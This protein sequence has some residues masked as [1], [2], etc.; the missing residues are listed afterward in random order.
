MKKTTLS[1]LFAALV[2]ISCVFASCN[3]DQSIIKDNETQKPEKDYTSLITKLEN[4][5]IE[6]KQNQYV[7]DAERDKEI[8]RLEGLIA[9]LK[10]STPD[11][12]ETES[13]TE[14]ETDKESETE[15]E[16]T[17]SPE[18]DNK[19]KFLYTITDS[20]AILTGYTGKDQT[21]VIPSSID[22][23][24]IIAIADN[25]FDSPTIKE[26]VV[27]SGVE[28]IGWFAFS[29]CYSLSSITLPDSVISIGYSAFPQR[30]SKFNIICSAE[31]FAAK[32]AQSYGINHTNI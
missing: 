22:G 21:L 30:N 27:P 32:Y 11:K 1:I 4:Q 24:E 17:S 6:L 13:E 5:I 2:C 3:A 18:T 29:E 7:S 20:G 16:P 15:K 25:A 8:L 10:P 28:K 19:G 14:T 23:Y 12:G 9:D 26:I 31:S